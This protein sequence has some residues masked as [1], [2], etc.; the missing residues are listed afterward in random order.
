MELIGKEVVPHATPGS[1]LG[2]NVASGGANAGAAPPM[3]PLNV[4][5][6]D[7]C[8]GKHLAKASLKGDLDRV[9]SWT[10]PRCGCEWNVSLKDSMRLW[11][12]DTT[13]AIVRPR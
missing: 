1:L 12:P 8:C 4:W 6:E 9:T 5:P 10:C 13:I 3:R 11:N 2:D 7:P